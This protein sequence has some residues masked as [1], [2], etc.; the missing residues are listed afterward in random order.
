MFHNLTQ[1]TCK[2]DGSTIG[3][4]FLNMGETLAEFQIRVPDK[5]HSTGLK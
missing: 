1:D 2:G 5:R 3:I 4:S